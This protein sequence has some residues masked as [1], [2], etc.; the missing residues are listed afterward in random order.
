[1]IRIENYARNLTVL[2]P[3]FLTRGKFDLIVVPGHDFLKKRAVKRDNVIVTD[4]AP[5]L[6]QPEELDVFKDKMPDMSDNGIRVAVPRVGLLF[7]G[8]NRYFT[9]G[10]DLTGKIAEGIKEA[11]RRIDGCFCA[12]TSRRTPPAAE[13]VL[14]NALAGDRRCV[15][16]VSGRHDSDERTVE[17]ILA[18]SDVVVVSGESISMV[19]EAVS[20][21]RPVLVF[22]PEKKGGRDTKYE[23]FIENLARRGYVKVVTPVQIPEVVEGLMKGTVETPVLPDDNER[24]FREVHRLF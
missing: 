11:C 24:I 22:M 19:S 8:D 15:K 12:T 16:F 4:L 9:F 23:R 5:N 7:G 13:K 18:S 3:G 6:V 20:S 2:D 10:E 1:M 14:S 17:K 21:G